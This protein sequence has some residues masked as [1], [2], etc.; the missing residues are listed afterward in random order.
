LSIT[1]SRSPKNWWAERVHHPTLPSCQWLVLAGAQSLR[2]ARMQVQFCLY[3]RTVRV[4]A[5]KRKVLG[6]PYKNALGTAGYVCLHVCVWG[7]G[8][9]RERDRVG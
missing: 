2:H 5:P 9:G 8:G 6:G 4:M 3:T 7:G 1:S